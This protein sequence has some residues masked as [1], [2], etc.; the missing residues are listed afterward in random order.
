M[1]WSWQNLGDDTMIMAKSW[2]PFHDHGMNHG[3]MVITLWAMTTMV[4]NMATMP[5]LWLDHDHV[6]PWSWYE[7]GIMAK[8]C[9]GSHVFPT[10]DILVPI[11]L[12]LVSNFFQFTFVFFLFWSGKNSPLFEFWR[13][14]VHKISIEFVLHWFKTFL[15]PLPRSCILLVYLPRNRRIFLGFFHDLKK[16][17]KF[18]PTLPRNIAKILARNIKNPRT[19]LAKKPRCQALETQKHPMRWTFLLFFSSKGINFIVVFVSNLL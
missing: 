8:S 1:V 14:N 6:S 16:A 3:N 5:S 9:H 13:T 17:G 11:C 12:I 10:R 19:F 18:V 15:F 4:R 7:H 2:R